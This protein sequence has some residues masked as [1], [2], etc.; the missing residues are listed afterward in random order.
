[1]FGCLT[2][3]DWQ[4]AGSHCRHGT[5]SSSDHSA[6]SPPLDLVTDSRYQ[7]Y[8]CYALIVQGT[9]GSFGHS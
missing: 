4:G 7:S 8:S 5:S 1:M 9:H 2:F 3:G 6:L